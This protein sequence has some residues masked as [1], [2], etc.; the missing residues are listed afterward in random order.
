MSLLEV[1]EAG[2]S[3]DVDVRRRLGSGLTRRRAE[4]SDASK[5]GDDGRYIFN[6][7][8]HEF[9]LFRKIVGVEGDVCYSAVKARTDSCALRKP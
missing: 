8:V 3:D 2:S 4:S 6:M 9:L 5:T 1:S 7:P